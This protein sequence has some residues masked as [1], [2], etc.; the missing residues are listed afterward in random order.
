MTK[1]E[2]KKI[3]IQSYMSAVDENVRDLEQW[4]AR[5]QS[6]GDK[7]VLTE[8]LK[9]WKKAQAVGLRAANGGTDAQ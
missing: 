9:L 4:L 6:N 5:A 8:E 1:D 7:A 3:A 2:A